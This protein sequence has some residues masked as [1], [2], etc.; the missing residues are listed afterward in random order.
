MVATP[1][2]PATSLDARVHMRERIKARQVLV[3]VLTPSQQLHQAADNM[4]LVTW[5]DEALCDTGSPPPSTDL[6][7]PGGSTTVAS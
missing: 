5:A 1:T 6:L 7:V 3:D 4:Q 2:T